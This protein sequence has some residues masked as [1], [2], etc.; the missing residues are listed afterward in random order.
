VAIEPLIYSESIKKNDIELQ[1]MKPEE[2]EEISTNQRL[3]S[4]VGTKDGSMF[5]FD[6]SHVSNR[7]LRFNCEK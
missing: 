3:Q 4:L 2:L 7:V 1:K 6:P 5:I